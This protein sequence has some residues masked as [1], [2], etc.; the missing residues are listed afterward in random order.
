MQIDSTSYHSPNYSGRS[1]RTDKSP[2]PVSMLVIHST[3]GGLLS[4]L[5]WLC[6]PASKV[7]T[8][9]LISKAGKIYQLVP[10]HL[11]AWHAGK[12]RW[13]NLSATDIALGSIGIEL[14][15]A[16]TGRDPYPPAQMIALMELSRSLV[17]KYRIPAEMVVR[18]LDIAVPKGRKSDPAG[19]PWEKFMSDLYAADR[20]VYRVRTDTQIGATVRGQPSRKAERLMAM[21]AGTS[22]LHGRVVTGE[23][24]ALPGFGASDQWLALDQGG[25]VWLPLLETI[26][27]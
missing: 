5:R 25:Y 7:S 10:D 9:Y 22:P 14:E 12:S 20:P 8:H 13:R 16:N 18:H 1:N 26:P 24:T 2:R 23:M 3:V 11:S 6:N 21:S 17:K 19:F 15:N 4:S 27:G